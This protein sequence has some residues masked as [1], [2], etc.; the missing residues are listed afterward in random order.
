MEPALDEVMALELRIL[1]PATRADPDAVRRLL[2]P[3]FREFGASGR[4]WDRDAVV[5]SLAADPGG[6]R[7]VE[8]LSARALGEGAVLVTYAVVAPRRSLRSSVWVRDGGDWRVLFHQGTLAA[9][10]A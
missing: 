1:E 3:D 10:A 9:E 4:V 7:R 8:G 6:E 5:A 2:H